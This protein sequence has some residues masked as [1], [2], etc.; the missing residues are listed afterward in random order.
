MSN[1]T[2]GG[3]PVVITGIGVYAPGAA[4]TAAFWELLTAGRTATRKISFFDP[5]PYRSQV[6]C[7]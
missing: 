4:N 7:P 3:R 6:H 1:E 5:S 2:A